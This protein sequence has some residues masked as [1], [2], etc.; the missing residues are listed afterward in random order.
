M[1][2]RA[3][4][5]PFLLTWL[6]GCTAPPLTTAPELLVEPGQYAAAFE[7]A[8]GALVER[9]Y[10]LERVDAREGVIT[11]R[12]RT[13]A[14]LMTPW[15]SEHTSARQEVEDLV[16]DQERRVRV[17]FIPAGGGTGGDA[18]GGAGAAAGDL[19]AAPGPTV[20]RVEV[21]VD[22]VNHVGQRVEPTSIRLNS[23]YKDDELVQRQMY[24]QYAVP[25]TIDGPVSRALTRAI[26]ARLPEGAAR[27]S[28]P[29][30][31]PKKSI[32]EAPAGPPIPSR[33]IGP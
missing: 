20:A 8:K 31:P 7:A 9:G 16:N 14:G 23:R 6:A 26:L 13:S 17:T 19:R 25:W 4:L 18:A 15:S 2:R 11:S 30:A 3:A 29:P 10:E 27:E 22:R 5:A 28:S 12:P 1:T 33:Q 32:D 24:P 21:A